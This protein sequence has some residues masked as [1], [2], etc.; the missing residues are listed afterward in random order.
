MILVHGLVKMIRHDL[1]VGCAKGIPVDK[2][3]EFE[4]GWFEPQVSLGESF[5][6]VYVTGSPP[7][8]DE[9]SKLI[10]FTFIDLH[11]A[12]NRWL[13]V[14]DVKRSPAWVGIF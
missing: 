9:S 3:F 10:G 1:L 11:I 8:D 6:D 12:V 2:S 7:V 14:G 13:V 4:F 5:S